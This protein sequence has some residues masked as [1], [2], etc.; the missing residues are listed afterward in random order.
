M[1][2]PQKSS[3]RPL[4]FFPEARR[5]CARR[6]GSSR[7]CVDNE[8]FSEG[9][10][11][12]FYAL[13][14]RARGESKHQNGAS[15][16]TPTVRTGKHAH[17]PR[18]GTA[19]RNPLFFTSSRRY[20]RQGPPGPKSTQIVDRTVRNWPRFVGFFWLG[21]FT[22]SVGTCWTWQ[23]RGMGPY[24]DVNITGAMSS[25][26]ETCVGPSPCPPSSPSPPPWTWPSKYTALFSVCLCGRVTSSHP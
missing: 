20:W 16:A 6:R 4:F 8:R 15:V 1:W 5:D 13:L 10:E 11:G 14:L 26:H 19:P 22:G 3:P 25:M 17:L 21:S 12:G 7:R 9:D 24:C 23:P 18:A 2:K